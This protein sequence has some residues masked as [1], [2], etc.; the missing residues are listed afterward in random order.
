MHSASIIMTG[1]REDVRLSIEYYGSDPLP[2]WAVLDS[3][4][5][6]DYPPVPRFRGLLGILGGDSDVCGPPGDFC[7]E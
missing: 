6:P 3:R 5:Y 1:E 7:G 4:C 2:I